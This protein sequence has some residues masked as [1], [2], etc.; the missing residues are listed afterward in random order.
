MSIIKNLLR[1][2]LASRAPGV[3]EPQI[4]ASKETRELYLEL[5]KRCLMNSIYDDDEDMMTGLSELNPET[6]KIRFV[7][8]GSVADA[9]KK[10]DGYIWPSKAHTMIGRARLDDLHA[11]VVDVLEEGTPGDLIE[12]GAWR[13][14]ASI[15]MRAVLKAY[16]VR[17]RCVWVAD[18]FEGLPVANETEHPYDSR[19][20]LHLSESLAVG[21]DEVKGN[22]ARY[23][24]LDEQVRFLKGWFCDTL[25]QAPIGQLAILRLDGDHFEST[26]DS[27]QSLYPKLSVGGYVLIDDY[28]GMEGCN[29]AIEAFRQEHNIADSLT[30]LP[31]GGARWKRSEGARP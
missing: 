26:M 24:L 17:D 22:F 27:L 16:N 7:G 15:F 8:G 23:D 2:V 11:C 9:G 18:S 3:D 30:V 21:L 31:R 28:N 25:A 5:M 19:L 20:N 1:N 13:G 29:K 4:D 10:R 6:G 14:G 12:T